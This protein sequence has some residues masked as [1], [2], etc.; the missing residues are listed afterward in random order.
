MALPVFRAAGAKSAGT[1]AAVTVSAPAGIAT[2][3][4]EILIAEVPTAATCAI[5]NNGG[6]AWAAMTGSPITVT[7]G[8]RLYV[9]SRIRAGGDGDPQVTASADHVC[10]GRLAYQ[11]GTFDTSDPFELE[12]TSSETTSDT[13]FS[14]APGGTTGGAD[15]LV[16]VVSSILRDSNTASVPVCTNA[17]LTALASRANYCTNSGAGGGFGVT[18][19]A[20]ATAGSVGTFACTYAA[21]SPKSYIS[22]AIKPVGAANLFGASSV[23]ET[24]ATTTA[25]KLTAMAAAAVAESVAVATV[26]VRKT[27]GAVAVAETVGITT[28]GTVSKPGAT[29]LDLSAAVTTSG[30]VDAKAAA[31]LN[32]SVAAATVGKLTALGVTTLTET[33]AVTTA[34]TRT[35][36]GASA[37][38]ETVTVATNGLVD[39]HAAASL[40]ET[41]ATSS[42]GTRDTFA[43]SAVTETVAITTAG[44]ISTG[45]TTH[46]GA[47]SLSPVATITTVGTVTAHASASLT[48]ALTATTTGTMEARSSSS[49]IA[50]VTIT[51]AGD[52]AAGPATYT[53]ATSLILTVAIHTGTGPFA[54]ASPGVILY[55][56]LGQVVG[57]KTGRVVA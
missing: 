10:A 14:W 24:V 21:A 50:A 56:P 20:R 38:D 1:T 22:F 33:V 48:A 52:I 8:E 12:T 42:A 34:A 6:G 9:W 44:D 55:A 53:G 46:F 31:S 47:T 57:P 39:A 2:G 45:P 37:V 15:R 28:A 51:T 23:A 35:R 5:T 17:S 54:A 25:A 13:S 3:D 26:G 4:L 36:L 29:S 16:L 41:V 27:F 18:E 11:A 30:R 7:A 43:A 19:G 40:T 49:L 32:L